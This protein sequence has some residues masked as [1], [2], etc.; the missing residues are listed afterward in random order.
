VALATQSRLI[1]H[2]QI[3]AAEASNVPA[4]IATV[5]EVQ[6]NETRLGQVGSVSGFNSASPCNAVL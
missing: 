6:A 2:R 1:A 5:H 4:F 3:A